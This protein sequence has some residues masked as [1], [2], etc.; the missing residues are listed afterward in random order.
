MSQSPAWAQW[1]RVLRQAPALGGGRWCR[2]PGTLL[3]WL[4]SFHAV[5][6][7]R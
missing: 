3:A 6:A 2:L 7:E 4:E 1:L 5:A